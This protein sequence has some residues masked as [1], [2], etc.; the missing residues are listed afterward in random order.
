M[1]KW[2]I[3]L[4]CHTAASS[5][6]LVKVKDLIK[7]AR[8]RGLD[9]LVITDHNTIRGALYAKTLDPDLIIVGEEILTTRGELLAFYVKEEIP[10]GLEP[11]EAIKRLRD[12]NAFISVSHPFDR[13]RHGWEVEDLIEITPLVDAIEIFNARSFITTINEAAKEYARVNNLRGTIG[14]DAHTLVE[15]GRAIQLIAPFTDSES[16]KQSFREPEY[17]TK[18]SSPM[19]RISSTSAKIAKT[20]FGKDK[21]SI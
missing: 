7:V 17:L 3:E 6:S 9:K 20:I 5:D 21:F 18:S 11:V 15:V 4:H 12:Q 1:Q 14:S 2:K 16:M 8:K 19:I 10:R 13:L